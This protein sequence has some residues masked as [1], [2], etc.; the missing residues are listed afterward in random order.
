MVKIRLSR[1]GTKNAP[2]YRIIA[3]DSRNK[4]D[5]RFLEVLGTYDPTVKEYKVTIKK[6]RLQHWLS[7][8]A[9][10]SEAV[11]RLIR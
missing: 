9:Q 5:G 7:Q 2:K 10:M 4:R 3:V 8:G 1:I 11:E 6:D